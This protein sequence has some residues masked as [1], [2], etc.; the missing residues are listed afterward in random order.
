MKAILAHE[1]DR[2]RARTR[3]LQLAGSLIEALGDVVAEPT[4][5]PLPSLDVTA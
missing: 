5:A 2:N 1:C 4:D 3:A